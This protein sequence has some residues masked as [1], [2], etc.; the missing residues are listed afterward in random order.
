MSPAGRTRPRARC[1]GSAEA[2]GPARPPARQECHRRGDRYALS[3]WPALPRYAGDGRIEIDNNAA[4]RA[5]RPV[6]LGRKNWLVVGSDQGG[7]RAAGILTLIK[8]AKLNGLDPH[9]YLRK[10]L[11]RIADHPINRIGD[12]LPSK[13]A[14]TH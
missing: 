14:P 13:I 4:E 10:V 3:R 9:R 6:A 12:L 5:I 1:R 2:G 11:T 8:T 7:E